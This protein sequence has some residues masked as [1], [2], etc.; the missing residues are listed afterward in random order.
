[1]KNIDIK[2][3]ITKTGNI[4]TGVLA[5]RRDQFIVSELD[6]DDLVPSEDNFFP[7]TGIESL[8]ENIEEFGL[9]QN[10]LVMR[11]KDKKYEIISG[12]RR[13]E[14]CRLLVQEGKRNSA[15]YRAGSCRNL[16]G[17]PRTSYLSP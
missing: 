13:R 11:R 3:L 14:A 12:H 10:L 8:K 7:L 6:V 5:G 2:G 17:Q 9:Q 15:G 16:M 1:M 4:N